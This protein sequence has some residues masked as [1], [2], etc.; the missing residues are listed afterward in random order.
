MGF[1]TYF[2][3]FHTCSYKFEVQRTPTEFGRVWITEYVPESPLFLIVSASCFTQK[4]TLE[5][6]VSSA[7]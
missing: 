1:R 3:Y 7:K 2:A 4:K 6:A 5:R